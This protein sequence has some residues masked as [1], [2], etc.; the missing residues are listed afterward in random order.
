MSSTDYDVVVVG[1]GF[2]GM[3]ALHKLRALGLR[4]RVFETGEDV[5]GT[6][7]WNRYP[8]CRCDVESYEYSYSFSPELEQDWDWSERYAT[9]PEILDYAKHVA[10]RFDLRADIQFATKV[11]AARYDE[12]LSIWTI[13]VETGQNGDTPTSESVTSTYMVLATG[14]LSAAKLPEFEGLDQ[15]KGDLY[16]TGFWPHEEVNLAGKHVGV[17]GTG[18]SG[19]QAIPILAQQAEHLSVFQR[20]PSY[21][22][23]ARNRPYS[24]EEK[25]QIK[26]GYKDVRKRALESRGALTVDAATGKSAMEFSPEEQED[27]LEA[28]WQHGGAF[29][30]QY[31]FNDALYNAQSNEV[32]AR[33]VRTKIGE[34]VT[35]P[36]VAERLTPSHMIATKRLCLDTGYYDTFN[37]QNVSLIDVKS[38][39][40]KRFNED[41]I[42]TENATYPLDAVVCATG[43]D[44]ITG[45]IAKIDIQGRNGLK[46]KD[47]WEDGARAY[48][49]VMS[50]GF[51]NMFIV[52]GP[53]SPSVFTNVLRSIEQHVEWLSDC[54][55]D[56]TGQGA[57]SIEATQKAENDWVEHVNELAD[58]ALYNNSDSW[59]NGS[60]VPGKPRVFLP[61]VG[62]FP[63]F[64]AHCEKIVAAGYEGFDIRK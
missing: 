53:G 52:T 36:D 27:I 5:G 13:E 2:A 41:G 39:P 7:Y 45:A 43:F 37:Q 59:Y 35:D 56:M 63:A 25:A 8:G 64:K 44:A 9:Q 30:F 50:A 34:L 3:Y 19:I 49:G 47:K 54:I 6:W 24:P 58:A 60:N 15:F 4:V 40:I 20:T 55:E 18:S 12:T 17:I 57:S 23:P 62:G 51:P 16:H 33:F 38:D 26:A 31:A 10:D 22:I 29:Q 32:L 11:C 48:L 21:S 1:A 42:E 61:Y 14:C 46:L 28:R